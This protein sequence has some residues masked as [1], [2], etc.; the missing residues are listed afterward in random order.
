MTF[1][2]PTSRRLLNLLHVGNRFRLMFGHPLNEADPDVQTFRQA[3]AKLSPR[4]PHEP[5]PRH[6]AND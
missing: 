5:H 2:R 1:D 4:E 3:L 6:Q